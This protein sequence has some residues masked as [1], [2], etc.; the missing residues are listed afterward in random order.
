[1]VGNSKSWKTHSSR[2]IETR[3]RPYK[4]E[5]WGGGGWDKVVGDG[6]WDRIKFLVPGHTC[7]LSEVTPRSYP[8]KSWGI[9][10]S[11]TD[12]WCTAYRKATTCDTC[13]GVIPAT[14][15]ATCTRRSPTLKCTWVSRRCRIS[16]RA[17]D[18][19]PLAIPLTV[20]H[21]V[22]SSLSKKN[23]DMR[24]NIFPP[25]RRD[26][27][28]SWTWYATQCQL[29]RCQLYRRCHFRCSSRISRCS[30][31]SPST[32]IHCQRWSASRSI[33]RRTL[34]ASGSLSPDTS[35]KKVIEARRRRI[36]CFWPFK[37]MPK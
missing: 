34:T 16:F 24:K 2:G 27:V 14:T 26:P 35:A 15:T 1:M 20:F 30:P 17:H 32:L 31:W 10:T 13:R 23:R 25:L 37:S 18:S 4:F 28:S 6:R 7:R 8:R 3:A 33:S 12:I 21:G 5:R 11:W 29:E 22:V 9:R 19:A 36:E